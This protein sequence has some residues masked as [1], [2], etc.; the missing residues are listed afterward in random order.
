[1]GIFSRNMKNTASKNTLRQ[2]LRRGESIVASA[3]RSGVAALAAALLVITT[4]FSV[5]QAV[6]A[7]TAE[8]V[9]AV[10]RLD[11]GDRIKITVFGHEDLS[12]EFEVDGTGR[13]AM[14]L[15]QFVEV[16]GLSVREAESAIEGKLSPDY[17]KN[18]KAS[19]EILNYR[20]FYILGEVENPGSYQYVTGMTVLESVAL[21]GG[22]TYR[23]R[24]KKMTVI[25]ASDPEK[26]KVRAWIDTKVLPGDV[27]EVPERRF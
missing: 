17:L 20:P 11:T 18:P 15:I 26:K 8:E 6:A 22:F 7:E 1:M 24:Q 21:A 23:A 14:P 9:D 12:G 27:I 4:S 16:G 2:K 13:V 10:Y 3:T 19:V 25:R 5:D